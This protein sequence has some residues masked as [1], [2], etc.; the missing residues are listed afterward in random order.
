MSREKPA[1]LN[2]QILRTAWGTNRD[3][4]YTPNNGH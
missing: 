3:V 4:R 1:T 2:Q